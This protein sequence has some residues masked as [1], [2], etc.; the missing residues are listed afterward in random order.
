MTKLLAV[1]AILGVVATGTGIKTLG[2]DYEI[3]MV[4]PNANNLF[5]GGSVVRDGYVDELGSHEELVA[6]GGA[7]AELWASWH[8]GGR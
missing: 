2:N 3:T 4:L 6:A 5:V 1:L 8:G 7:Y